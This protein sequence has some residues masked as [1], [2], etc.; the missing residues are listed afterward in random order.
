MVQLAGARVTPEAAVFIGKRLVYRGR[1]DDRYV[2]FG[3]TRPAP[4]VHDLEQ[5]LERI[6][7][8]RNVELQTTKAVGCFIED[9]K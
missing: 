3:T 5:V 6:S 1:I 8:G 2:T 7:S 4:R 9:L